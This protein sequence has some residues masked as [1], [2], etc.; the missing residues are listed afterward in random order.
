MKP[1]RYQRV[2]TVAEALDAVARPGTV[3]LAGGTNLMDLMYYGVEAP[4]ALVDINHLDLTGVERSQDGGLRIGALVRNTDLANHPLVRAEYPLLS[5]A[6]LSGA[7]T[8]LRNRATVGGNLLQRTRC[9]YF[10]DASFPA[11]NKRRPGSGCGAL[12]GQNRIHAI[13]GQTDRGPE[14]AESCIAVNPSDMSVALA[15]LDAVVRI[16]GP[17]G[18][19]DVPIGQFHRLPGATPWI[20]TVLRPGE[21]IVAVTLPPSRFAA[22]SHYLK[23]RDR[24]SYAYALVSVA[25]G[26]EIEDG[27]VR[28]AALALGGVALKPWRVPEADAW[29]VGRP[30][31]AGSFEA[32]ADLVLRGAQAYEHNEFKIPMA[33]RCVVRSLTLAAGPGTLENDA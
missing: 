29:L 3:F 12:G 22:A 15:A 13:L 26:L 4:A 31:A 7:S 30:A 28:S 25:A 16:D 11:C 2:S 24:T 19:R 1:F 21:L 23:A 32:A 5:Q 20:D 10:V 17:D 33:R 14:H 27:V 9:Y 18:G 8:Q 6:L